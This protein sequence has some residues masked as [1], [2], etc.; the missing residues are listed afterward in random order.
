MMRLR[1]HS[2]HPPKVKPPSLPLLV[3]AVAVPSPKPMYPFKQHRVSFSP[4]GSG[5][6]PH[7]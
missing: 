4:R 7:S 6:Q 2:P 1:M 5:S 3:S